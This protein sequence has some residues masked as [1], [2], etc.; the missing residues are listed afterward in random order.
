LC[1]LNKE[2][3]AFN[4]DVSGMLNGGKV[5]SFLMPISPSFPAADSII[6]TDKGIIPISNKKGGGT[7]ASFYTNL[8]PLLK[9]YSDNDL[10]TKSNILIQLKQIFNKFNN[11]QVLQQIYEWGFTYLLNRR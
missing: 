11:N 7:G 6:K 8:V 1:L 2:Y 9:D 10:K 3:N 4:G 5:E